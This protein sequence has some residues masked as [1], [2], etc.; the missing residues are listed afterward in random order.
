[1]HTVRLTDEY[2][3]TTWLFK[4]RYHFSFAEFSSREHSCRFFDPAKQVSLGRFVRLTDQK[5]Y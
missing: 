2:Y 4:K 3:L 1:M 5:L